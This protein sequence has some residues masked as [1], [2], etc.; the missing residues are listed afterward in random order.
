MAQLAP[1]APQ[2]AYEGQNVSAISLIANP[3]RNLDPLR[4]FVTQKAGDPYSEVKIQ[5][6]AKALQQAGG[7]PKVEVNVGARDHRT[8]N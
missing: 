2:A 8:S 4:E 6:S 5:A 3:H 7:F 1:Q